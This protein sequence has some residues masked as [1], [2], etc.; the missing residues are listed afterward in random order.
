MVFKCSNKILPI[1]FFD[2]STPSIRTLTGKGS[3]SIPRFL[4]APIKF[5]KKNVLI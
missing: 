5:A 1:K 2:M 3:S 4:V